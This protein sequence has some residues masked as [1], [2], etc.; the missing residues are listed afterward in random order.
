MQCQVFKAAPE[1]HLMMADT[2]T[3]GDDTR[4]DFTSN[5]SEYASQ[6]VTKSNLSWYANTPSVR[7]PVFNFNSLNENDPIGN[8][9]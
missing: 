6:K 2:E 3:P 7:I 4:A 1:D 9:L 8:E 5:A